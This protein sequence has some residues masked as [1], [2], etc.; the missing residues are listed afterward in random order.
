[1][2][3]LI[4]MV[5]SVCSVCSIS[6]FSVSGSDEDLDKMAHDFCQS[7]NFEEDCA[8]YPEQIREQLQGLTIFTCCLGFVISGL[9]VVVFSMYRIYVAK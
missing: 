3:L 1:M 6:T 9:I 8:D 2:L 7:D 4:M 5:F